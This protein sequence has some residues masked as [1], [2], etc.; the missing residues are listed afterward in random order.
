[1]FKEIEFLERLQSVHGEH[2]ILVLW[3]GESS[4]GVLNLDIVEDHGSDVVGV[5]LGEALVG[6]RVGDSD[7]LVGVVDDGVGHLGDEGLSMFV[8]LV[9]G[10]RDTDCLLYTSPSPRDKRQSRMPSSA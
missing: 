4:G 7:Q 3:H 2:E 1:M 8:S 10:V 5:L 6:L 9:L